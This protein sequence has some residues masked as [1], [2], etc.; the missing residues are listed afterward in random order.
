[1]TK[2]FH[3]VM[4]IALMWGLAGIGSCVNASMPFAVPQCEDPGSEDHG[5]SVRTPGMCKL[6]PCRSDQLH[7]FLMPDPQHRKPRIQQDGFFQWAG[8]VPIPNRIAESGALQSN[9][10]V[11]EFLSAPLRPSLFYLHCSMIC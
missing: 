10:S 3:I 5:L 1:M 7:F 8:P 4:S 9:R 6:F 11:K 2:Y